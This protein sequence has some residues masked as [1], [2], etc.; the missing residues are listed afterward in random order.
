MQEINF[1]G[2]IKINKPVG[3]T[4][5]DCIR[6]IKRILNIKKIKIGHAGTLDPFASGLMLICIGREATKTIDQ[7][8]TQDKEYLVKAKLGELTDTLDLTGKVLESKILESKILEPKTINPSLTKQDIEKAIKEL[9]T[10]YIQTPPIYSALKHQGKPLYE[11]AREQKMEPHEL[12]EI[13]Q[14]KS[15]LVEIYKIEVLNVELPFFTFKAHVSKGTYIRSL[16]EDIAQKL[17]LHATTYEL[18]RTKIGEYK[19]E[20]ATKLYDLKTV[21]DIK[22]LVV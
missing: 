19:L 1:S 12:E 7:L 5:Y 21:E 10:S 14:K 3:I 4:S 20:D 6:H 16:A 9:G 18:E 15:R 22:N 17:D 11:L 2:L 8:M 13:V